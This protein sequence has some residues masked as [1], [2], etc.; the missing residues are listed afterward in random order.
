MSSPRQVSDGD[1]TVAWVNG[2]PDPV[3]PFASEGDLVSWEW[4]PKLRIDQAYYRAGMMSSYVFGN[5]QYN[6]QVINAAGNP[7][8]LQLWQTPLGPGV[9]IDMGE[10]SDIGSG[11]YE[12]TPTI[13][14]GG[15]TAIAPTPVNRLIGATINYLVQVRSNLAILQAFQRVM[16]AQVLKEYSLSPLPVLLAPSIQ[17]NILGQ[18]ACVGDWNLYQFTQ[19]GMPLEPALGPIFGANV[20]VIATPIQAIGTAWQAGD[21]I[22]GQ[23]SKC[24]TYKGGMYY[25]E[26]WFITFPN[27][28]TLA[29]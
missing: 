4:K 7:A 25:R 9:L 10:P 17:N 2:A 20:G 22:V 16:L 5:V 26:T 18:I 14:G 3:Y 29:S 27:V 8:A 11:L 23:D 21:I 24:T 15:G 6:V 12:W 19:N 28:V 13:T 1:F